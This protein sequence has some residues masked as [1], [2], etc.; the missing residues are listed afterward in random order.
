MALVLQIR[1][2]RTADVLWDFN[3]PTG[4]T[5]PGGAKTF[6]RADGIDFGEID[7]ESG[8]APLLPDGDEDVFY[9]LPATS[10]SIQFGLEAADGTTRAAHRAIGALNRALTREGTELL[11]QANDT[12]EERIYDLL[13]SP[14]AVLL[15][16]Q[17]HQ[18]K[19]ASA[20]YEPNAAASFRR[21]PWSRG[22][23]LDS[24]TNLIPVNPAL[25]IEDSVNAGRPFGWNWASAA[26][27]SDEAIDE[28]G[29]APAYGFDIA[30]ADERILEGN[31]YNA[32]ASITGQTYTFAIF[33][34]SDA[35]DAKAKARITWQDAAAVD[36]SSDEQATLVTLPTSPP[37]FSDPS[38]AVL[39]VTATAPATAE[40]LEPKIVLDQDDAT[41]RR[42]Y[43]VM[44]Q[45]EEAISPTLWVP[46]EMVVLNLPTLGHGRSYYTYGHGDAEAPTEVSQRMTDINAAVQVVR[47]G[48]TSSGALPAYLNGANY[49]KLSLPGNG[50]WTITQGDDTAD[51]TDANAWESEVS[52]VTYATDPT[53]LKRRVRAVNTDADDLEALRG[54]WDIYVRVKATVDDEHTLRLHWSPAVSDPAVFVGDDVTH[55]PSGASVFGFVEKRLGR[56]RIPEEG[57]VG[58]ITLELWTA[59]EDTSARLRI[60]GFWLVPAEQAL[61]LMVPGV[62]EQSFLGSELA[63]PPAKLTADPA[64]IA[65]SVL[66]SSLRLNAANEGGGVPPNTGTF[67]TG[68]VTTRFHLSRSGSSQTLGSYT[69]R[70]VNVTDG[71]VVA[72]QSGAFPIFTG[73]Q[74][75]LV[76]THQLVWSPLGAKKYQAQVV[77]TNYDSGDLFVDRIDI[78]FGNPLA[79]DDEVVTDSRLLTAIVRDS[80]GSI[81]QLLNVAG[82]LP[83]IVPGW[84]AVATYYEDRRPAPSYEEGESIKSAAAEVRL[85]YSPRYLE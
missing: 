76:I 69:V 61:E 10:G 5:N 33:A 27:I 49:V 22:P 23:E 16:G 38:E 53:V 46:G 19:I 72:S 48:R 9:R 11:Y 4:A 40:R 20:G 18:L 30:T 21:Q 37:N 85:A 41:P 81:T 50:N 58:G 71:N 43:L 51:L 8:S 63:T 31:L 1:D 70:I 68:E 45:S 26:N 82:A 73:S 7:S 15:H 3:D 56:I 65:G 55:D 17:E 59:S 77:V 62:G 57:D 6:V 75:S 60:D 24:R 36:I 14:P 64:W 47:A 80:P 2:R 83:T 78:L 34:W 35:A 32:G 25:L 79:Q 74:A 28:A 54:S 13:R 67:Y 44:A 42:I 66:G 39:V 29:G 12:D 84:Q 52:Q